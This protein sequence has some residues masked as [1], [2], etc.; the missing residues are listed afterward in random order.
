M[1][2]RV[3]LPGDIEKNVRANQIPT[4][5]M[6]KAP[7][8]PIYQLVLQCTN[9]LVPDLIPKMMIPSILMDFMRLA[10]V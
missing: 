8:N 9:C 1:E 2:L 7:F 6:K 4:F 10:D 3:I 5:L